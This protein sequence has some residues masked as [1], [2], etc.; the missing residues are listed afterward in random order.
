MYRILYYKYSVL[1]SKHRTKVVR[2]IVVGSGVF[3]PRECFDITKH[4][5]VKDVYINDFTWTYQLGVNYWSN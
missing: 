3:S 5:R 1:I 2:Y 4:Q